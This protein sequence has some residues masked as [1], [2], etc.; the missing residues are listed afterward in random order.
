MDTFTHQYQESREAA[1][2]RLAAK[3]RRQGVKLYRDAKDGR[4]YASSV[5]R[6]GLMHYVTGVSCD[7]AGFAEYARCKHHSA[8]IVALGWLVEDPAPEPEPAVTALPV[9]MIVCDTCDGRGSVHGTVPTGP[10]TWAYS[11][12]VC[13]DCHGRGE[14][15][16]VRCMDTGIVEGWDEGYGQTRTPCDCEAGQRLTV[17]DLTIVAWDTGQPVYLSD[18]A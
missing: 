17:R 7:C 8:L 16:C 18:A 5:S 1:I 13:P 4:Y 11:D 3:A 6:P 2:R 15:R 10:T 14:F 12:V 9:P